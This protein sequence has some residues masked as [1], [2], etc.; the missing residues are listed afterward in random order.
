M[1]LSA[2]A[3]A[4]RLLTARQSG[5]GCGS[6]GLQ[7]LDQGYAVQAELTTLWRSAGLQPFGY[8]L[9]LT[10]QRM[11]QATGVSHPLYGPLR[12]QWQYASPARLTEAGLLSPRVE[13]EVAFVFKQGLDDA[14]ASEAQLRAALSHVLP[15]LEVCDSAFLGWPTSLPDALADNLSCGL[16]VLGE[17]PVAVDSLD[18]ASL[19]MNL[20]CNGELAASGHASQCM[21]SPLQACLWLVRELAAQGTPIQAGEIVLSGALGPML[22]INQGD[23]VQLSLGVLGQVSCQF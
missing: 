21:G 12:R 9:G 23:R 14:N 17:Q 19:E 5:Q 13:G 6:L 8:K 15:A 10:D 18:F 7:A 4:Q 3:A 1:R 16:Y 11:Q 2:S 20:L 22:R